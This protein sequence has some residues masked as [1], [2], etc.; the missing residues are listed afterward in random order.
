MGQIVSD[1]VVVYI[2]SGSL[3][4]FFKGGGGGAKLFAVLQVLLL[5][6][7]AEKRFYK[8]LQKTFSASCGEKLKCPSG[9]ILARIKDVQVV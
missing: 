7:E 3:I 5:M 2:V 8:K 9:E 4:L 1:I 6:K